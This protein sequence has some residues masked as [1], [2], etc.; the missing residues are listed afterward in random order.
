MNEKCLLW[1]KTP[2]SHNILIYVGVDSQFDCTVSRTEKELK[3]AAPEN[4]N[5]SLDNQHIYP[6]GAKASLEILVQLMRRVSDAYM[7]VQN[8]IQNTEENN[9]ESLE[10]SSKQ[11][12]NE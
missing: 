2:G 6:V 10:D 4:A 1:Y 12:M 8:E 11:S 3:G 7:R 5:V 9:R